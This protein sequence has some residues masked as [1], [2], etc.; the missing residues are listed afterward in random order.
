MLCMRHRWG[1]D[2]HELHQVLGKEQIQGPIKGD[3]HFPLKA[4]QLAQVD[5]AP[6]PPGQKAGEVQAQD[7]RHPGASANGRQLAQRG[8]DKRLF[9][10]A[11]DGRSNIA[12]QDFALPQGMLGGWRVIVAGLAVGDQ[13]AITQGPHA[14]PLGDFQILVD[15][16]P[17]ALFGTGEGTQEMIGRSAGRP[18]EGVRGNCGAVA[19]FH[20]VL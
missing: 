11:V 4:R 14:W 19:E 2:H 12:G 16:D 6:Q 5:G 15:Q 8:E 18:D 20:T 17:T 7:V 3:A 13:G 9:A 1:V 10:A